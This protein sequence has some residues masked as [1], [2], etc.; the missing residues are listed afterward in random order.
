MVFGMTGRAPAVDN[1]PLWAFWAENGLERGRMV[2]HW[3]PDAPV[4]TSQ[5]D[6]LATTWFTGTG[7]V[8]ALA[9]WAE[10]T[11][12][13]TLNFPAGEI[14]LADSSLEAPAIPGF[15]SAMSYK[16]GDPITVEPQRGVLLTI[17]Y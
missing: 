14:Y 17:G 15:Q 8:I 13:V 2:G 11:V 10:E 5:P 9:S 3:D 12:D 7:I 4:H 1:R 16:P 6:I